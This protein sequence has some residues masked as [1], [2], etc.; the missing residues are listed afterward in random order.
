MV[1]KPWL[2]LTLRRTG[3]TSLTG[4]LAKVSRFRTI[5][6][7][8]FN[9]D[10][11]LAHVT[12]LCRDQDPKPLMQGMCDALRDRPNIK[13]CFEF[14]PI[15]LTMALITQADRQGYG[16]MLLTRRD[17]AKRQLSL[18]VAMATG[19]WGPDA[20]A[21]IY[22]AIEAG[23]ITPPGIDLGALKARVRQDYSALG[24]VLALLRARRIA[25]DWL[26]FEELYNRP[27]ALPDTLLAIASGLGVQVA[28]D[29]PR[30]EG[31]A[32]QRGQ[33][34]ARIA[35]RIGNHDQAADLLARLCLRQDDFW[36]G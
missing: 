36:S 26:L 17:E 19:A 34:S 15:A 29:D 2:I 24:Q 30:L 25:H 28:P 32:G 13:H 22:P 1:E 3:G 8:P 14:L 31:L 10:R 27:E 18:A 16:I 9:R 12:A 33:D 20:A 7:E 11:R 23:E 21:R 6:H 4:F 5:E 35:P